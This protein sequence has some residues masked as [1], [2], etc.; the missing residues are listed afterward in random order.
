MTNQRPISFI[1]AVFD[2][3]GAKIFISICLTAGA[4]VGYSVSSGGDAF[5]IGAAMALGAMAVLFG[6]CCL[7]LV[8][9][10]T[11]ETGRSTINSLREYRK[12]GMKP[13]DGGNAGV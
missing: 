6:S 1:K 13:K 8:G 5:Q 2:L 10:L 3:H 4:I 7:T 11:W 12:T 9:V